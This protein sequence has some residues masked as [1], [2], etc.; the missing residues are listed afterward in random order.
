MCR[1]TKRAMRAGAIEPWSSA[2]MEGDGNMGLS[3]R[4]Y[5]G[6]IRHL[7]FI[8]FFMLFVLGV[9]VCSRAMMSEV[10]EEDLS[11]VNAQ[12]GITYVIG[13]S[14]FRVSM[15]S[16]QFSDTESTPHNWIQLNGVTVDDGS[17]GYFSMNTPASYEDFNTTDVGTDDQ[18]FT[19]VFMNLSLTVEPRTLTVGDFVFCD[20]P[21]GSL[22]FEDF[23][24]TP[25][26]QF[27][28]S[29][30]NDGGSGINFEYKTELMLDSARYT[31]KGTVAAPE[32]ELSF[33][34]IHLAQTAVEDPLVLPSLWTYT[35]QFQIGDRAEGNPATIDV[36][37]WVT[38]TGETATSIFYNFPMKGSVRIDNV[39]FG[40]ADFGPCAIS[41]INVHRALIALPG[42]AH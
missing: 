34:G 18:G 24:T 29:G 36:G 6:G 20:V 1:N 42:T 38:E 8:A 2:G 40:G 4:R 25:S 33:D 13:D 16:Y 31:Y 17:G 19:N 21:L 32:G 15:N 3:V 37:T 22:R 35:G 14:R 12:S 28:V 9:P 27:I 23:R 7:S 5:L 26:N 41:G 39:R 10:S 11:N 30:R